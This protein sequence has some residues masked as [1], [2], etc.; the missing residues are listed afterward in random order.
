MDFD[1]FVKTDKS[2]YRPLE[3]EIT[4]GDNS[5][6]KKLLGWQY[7][8]TFEQLIDTFVNDEIE[9]VSRELEEGIKNG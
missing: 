7:D 2:L 8:M 1:N 5:K 3:L 6:A 9:Y 4:H